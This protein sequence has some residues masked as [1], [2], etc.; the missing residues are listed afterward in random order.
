MILRKMTLTKT[1]PGLSVLYF[2]YAYLL[3]TRN[4]GLN[5]HIT[6]QVKRDGHLELL[7]SKSLLH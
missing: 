6:K 4:E 5:E 2:D 1:L 3:R 7:Y